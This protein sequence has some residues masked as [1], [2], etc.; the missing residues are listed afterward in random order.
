[1]IFGGKSTILL[2]TRGCGF[3]GSHMVDRLLVEE[4]IVRVIDNW[5]AGRKE[6][7]DY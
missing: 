6:N 1:M 7:L 5:S 3:I 4:H 2:V